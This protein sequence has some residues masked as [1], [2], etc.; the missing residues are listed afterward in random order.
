VVNVALPARLNVA[1]FCSGVGGLDLAFRRVFPAARTVLYSEN[2]IYAAAVLAA[3]IGEGKLCDAPIWSDLRQ[4]DGGP[5]RGAVDCILG[6][7]SCQDISSAGKR[8]GITGPKSSIWFQFARLIR[9]MDPWLVVLENVDE[10][11]GRGL[12]VVLG[13][14]AA[15]GFDAEWL[16]LRASDVGA[17]HERARIFIIA[18]GNAD[19]VREC[20]A[21]QEGETER[22][23]R[24]RP[25]GDA[26]RPSDIDV[27]DT[28]GDERQWKSGGGK[29]S[30]PI[31]T[32]PRPNRTRRWPTPTA[33]DYRSSGAAGYSTESGR[34]SG[35][36]LTDA[37]RE[38]EREQLGDAN[39]ARLA[40]RSGE[41]GYDEAQ[42]AAPERTVGHV[43]DWPP[44]RDDADRWRRYLD[45]YP[46]LR[47]A[48]DGAQPCVCGSVASTPHRVD[49]HR[50]D[51]LIAL[52]NAVNPE[53]AEA[54]IRELWRRMMEP[55]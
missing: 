8:L 17:P 47:P 5:W 19:R 21:D 31:P 13:D 25:R 51:R 36:T 27:A 44:G 28:D 55:I 7:F 49:L 24:T 32:E 42:F 30:R 54:A 12:G 40:Q 43:V 18:M 15:L 35:T 48:V 46:G 22:D 20:G 4:L 34:H 1:S 14:L 33:M 53:Q 9:E 39:C 41:R 29:H 45:R 38:R 23:R 37:I 3:R 6:G 16:C 11:V 52:G 10:L 2:E 50:I 26:E